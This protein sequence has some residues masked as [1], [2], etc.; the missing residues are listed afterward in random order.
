MVYLA[1]VYDGTIGWAY[2]EIDSDQLP[3]YRMGLPVTIN[4]VESM[5]A[6]GISDFP[7]DL[8][9][10]I[11]KLPR[12]CACGSGFDNPGIFGGCPENTPYCG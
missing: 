6:T 4:I 3:N 12:E 1:K 7:S 9:T 8:V 10:I 2:G 11:D 5:I